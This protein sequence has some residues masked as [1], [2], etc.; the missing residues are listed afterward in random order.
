MRAMSAART[1]PP[2][3]KADGQVSQRLAS[4]A[5]NQFLN[6]LSML[7]ELVQDFRGSDR[8]VKYK[9]G[10]FGGWVFIS[11]VSIIIACPGRGV[12]TTD[13]G[14]RVTVLPN[15]DRPKAAPS[16]LVSN[17]DS[18]PWEDVVFVVNGKYRATVEKIDAGGIF[19]LTPKSLLSPA[20]PMPS[21]E[22]FVNAEMRTKHGKAELVKDGQPMTK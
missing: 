22:H 9:A 21:D 2:G 8:F 19:T 18:D 14:A 20:G 16:M 7:K 3:K 17:T 15:A 11:L 1:A 6:I 12:E 4:E 5:S 13:L 10:I